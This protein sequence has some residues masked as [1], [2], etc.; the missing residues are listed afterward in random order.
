MS[1]PAGVVPFKKG[2]TRI[3]NQPEFS[4]IQ[5]DN[6]DKTLCFL[7]KLR[8][9]WIRFLPT[10]LRIRVI[11]TNGKGEWIEFVRKNLR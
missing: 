6:R 1:T 2:E 5:V 3:L 11:L 4:L 8:S 10:R 7:S 9:H